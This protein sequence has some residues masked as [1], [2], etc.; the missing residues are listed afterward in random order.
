MRQELDL[1]V[2]A[3]ILQRKITGYSLYGERE[4]LDIPAQ[5]DGEA[6][7]AVRR[8]KFDRFLLDAAEKAGVQV[9]RSRVYEHYYRGAFP[10]GPARGP[11]GKRLSR[12]P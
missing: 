12:L 9:E 1:T 2:P 11:F 8:V 5:D 3:A 10:V 7:Y 4:I 6:T